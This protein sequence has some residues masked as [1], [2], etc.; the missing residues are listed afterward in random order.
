MSFYQAL[1]PGNKNREVAQTFGQLFRKFRV[2]GEPV[3]TEELIKVC[4]QFGDSLTLENL[5]RPQL[6]SMCRYM[7]I[8]AFGTD[9]YLRYAIRNKMAK[10]KRDDQVSNL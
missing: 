10:L 7:N 1:D 8:N 6:V 3:S 5:S 4:Q 2:T 9:N